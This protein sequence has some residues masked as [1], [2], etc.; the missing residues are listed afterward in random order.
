MNVAEEIEIIQFAQG[1]LTGYQQ[2]AEKSYAHPS[3]RSEFVSL[4]KLW[5]EDMISS[6]AK[7]KEPEPAPKP[8]THFDFVDYNEIVT[9]SIEWN[10]D[11]LTRAITLL[12]DSL[13]K[14]ISVRYAIDTEQARKL[15]FD[16]VER[17]LRETYHTDLMGENL[18]LGDQPTG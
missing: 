1:I 10:D 2:R 11:K 9:E 7:Y 5:Y 12:R 18:S 4:A 15:V 3:F 13:T 17:H 6:R 16:V 14:A 8:Q